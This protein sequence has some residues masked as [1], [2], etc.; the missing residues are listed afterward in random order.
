MKYLSLAFLTASFFLGT[1]ISHA[2]DPPE[3]AGQNNQSSLDLSIS[4]GD[5][6]YHE[7]ASGNVSDFVNASAA[8][9]ALITAVNPA[10]AAVVTGAT[11]A[12]VGAYGVGRAGKRLYC[13]KRCNQKNPVTVRAFEDF[14]KKNWKAVKSWESSWT[15]YIATL[16]P[17]ENAEPLSASE[18]K[19]F[20]AMRKKDLKEDW[21]IAAKLSKEYKASVKSRSVSE[22]LKRKNPFR[23]KSDEEYKSKAGKILSCMTGCSSDSTKAHHCGLFKTIKSPRLIYFL[24]NVLAST[25]SGALSQ[26]TEGVPY[27][28]SK[29]NMF[30]T[31]KQYGIGGKTAAQACMDSASQSERKILEQNLLILKFMH[32]ENASTNAHEKEVAR[33]MEVVNLGDLLAYLKKYTEAEGTSE[34]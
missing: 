31:S 3:V 30:F 24:G 18:K 22:R 29:L 8:G 17:S 10:A 27:T 16:N 32:D 28:A 13:E 25:E 6:G 34:A 5:R 15:R 14:F 11:A 1:S 26:K 23:K 12:A 7:S 19:S 2:I 4:K 9:V 33:C 21:D 20:D